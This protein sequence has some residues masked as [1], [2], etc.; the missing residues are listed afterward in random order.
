VRAAQEVAQERGDVS[1]LCETVVAT[2]SS[3]HGLSRVLSAR[4]EY[5]TVES[6]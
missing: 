1:L 4:D 2:Q 6:I 3:H 5:K